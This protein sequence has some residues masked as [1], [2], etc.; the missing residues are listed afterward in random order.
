MASPVAF[1]LTLTLPGVEPDAGETDSQEESVATVYEK[2]A[3][4]PLAMVTAWAGGEG[5]PIA[6]TKLRLDGDGAME[7]GG[8]T[9]VRLTLI[10]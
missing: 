1:T 5:C 9:T 7:G 6:A 10:T 4:P 8:V 2:L 3:Y